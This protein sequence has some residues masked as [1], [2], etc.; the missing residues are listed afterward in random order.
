MNGHAGRIWLGIVKLRAPLPVNLFILTAFALSMPGTSF[1]DRNESPQKVYEYLIDRRNSLY[2]RF[3]AYA[4]LQRIAD[5]LP[6]ENTADAC[7][8]CG[9]AHANCLVDERGSVL[10]ET[11]RAGKRPDYTI[12]IPFWR[13]AAEAGNTQAS[14]QLGNLYADG[15]GDKTDMVQAVQYWLIAGKAGN[16]EAIGQIRRNLLAIDAQDKSDPIYAQA[17]QFIAETDTGKAA[18]QALQPRSSQKHENPELVPTDGGT[19]NTTESTVPSV[20]ASTG[21]SRIGGVPPIGKQTPK[22]TPLSSAAQQQHNATKQIAALVVLIWAAISL[23]GLVAGLS[24]GIIVYRSWGDVVLSGLI[25]AAIF[26]TV[27]ARANGLPDSSIDVPWKLLAGCAGCIAVLLLIHSYGANH[28]L[29]KSLIA[30]PTQLFVVG[31][32]LVLF[33]LSIG[34]MLLLKDSKTQKERRENMVCAIASGA[35]AG[36]SG[37]LLYKLVRA[38]QAADEAEAESVES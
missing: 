14:L 20:D 24:G 7:W 10:S 26:A 28:S 27:I 21:G 30:V 4:R 8:L 9:L 32:L 34:F 23:I 15:K 1:A 33:L 38:G 5:A 3:N 22:T 37:Y 11:Q 35:G 18:Q 2:N 16:Q 19:A 31:L 29:L 17:S 25:F 13:K 6:N 12:V 36:I